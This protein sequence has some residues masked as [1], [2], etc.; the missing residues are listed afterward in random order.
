MHHH[1]ILE[2]KPRNKQKKNIYF[3]GCRVT[4][5]CSLF[6]IPNRKLI[7]K[8]IWCW[9]ECKGSWSSEPDSS[10]EDPC[11]PQVSQWTLWHIL[12]T[13]MPSSPRS[14]TC[15]NIPQQLGR[16]CR[17]GELCFPL[18]SHTHFCPTVPAPRS[19]HSAPSS[20]AAPGPVPAHCT[21]PKRIG[22]CIKGYA[23]SNKETRNGSKV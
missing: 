19:C 1:L 20:H 7:N 12:S 9:A 16:G 3:S 18:P 21:F 23:D 11:L 13:E 15:S 10:P 8:T 6:H 5:K 2:C 22:V 14:L 4:S 17:R